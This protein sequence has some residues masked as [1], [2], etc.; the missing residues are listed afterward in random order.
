MLRLKTLGEASLTR[1]DADGRAVQLLAPGRALAFVT[2][3][4]SLPG[5]TA[6]RE[7]LIDLLWANLEPTVARHALRQMV[8]YLRQRL[9]DT[10]LLTKKDCQR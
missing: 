10:V 2:H 6:N 5:Q 9:G 7:Q 1:V 8:W 4:V 3:L